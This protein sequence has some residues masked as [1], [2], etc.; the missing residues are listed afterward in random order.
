LV[1][2][3]IVEAVVGFAYRGDYEKGGNQNGTIHMGWSGD[4]D[5]V[6]VELKKG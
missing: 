3:Q 6:F 2:G 5:T 4:A 1:T